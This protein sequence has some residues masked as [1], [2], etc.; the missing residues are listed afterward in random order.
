VKKYTFRVATQNTT[1]SLANK[2]REQ[3]TD[4]RKNCFLP[5]EVALYSLIAMGG[6]LR[7][8]LTIVNIT[9]FLK[10]GLDAYTL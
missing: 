9:G 3:K 5:D 4:F 8:C 1:F 10:V 7:L 6:S 2:M